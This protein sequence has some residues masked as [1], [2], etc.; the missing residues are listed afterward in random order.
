MIDGDLELRQRFKLGDRAAYAA[1][2]APHLD[3]SYTLAL[4]MVGNE[5]EAADLAQDAL[6]RTL[7]QHDRYD[8]ARPF[9]PWLLTVTANLCRDRL[10]ST[11]WR[12]VAGLIELPAAEDAP[13]DEQL[14]I[15]ESDAGVRRALGTLPVHYREALS[16]YYLQEMT[17]AEMVQITGASEAALK[18]RVRR[19]TLML[20]AAY[21]RLYPARAASRILGRGA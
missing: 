11:W 19:G 16:L 14:A 15:E 10:R 9:R 7:E 3:T 4:R 20:E 13:L 21:G 12:R 6:V 1:I 5:A 8:P 17:Y 2:V 18:Q